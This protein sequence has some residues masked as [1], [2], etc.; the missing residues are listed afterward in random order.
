MALHSRFKAAAAKGKP[1][2]RCVPAAVK[3][4]DLFPAKKID[5]LLKLQ[6]SAANQ[7]SAFKSRDQLTMETIHNNLEFSH[8]SSQVWLSHSESE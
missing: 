2:E 7:R 4:L 3:R 1:R 6:P 8:D 5:D